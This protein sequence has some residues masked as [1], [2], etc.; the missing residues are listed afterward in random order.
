MGCTPSHSDIVNSVAKSGIQFF[1][2]PKA[3]LP[4]CQGASER[5]SIPFLVQNSTCYDSG[6]GSSQGQRPAEEQQ[7][8]RWIQSVAESLCQLTRDSTSGKRK[9]MEG[10][11]PETKTSP[12]QLNKS[13]SYVATDIPFKRQ[14]SHGS[15]GTA[16]SG[17]ESE[18]SNTQ[19]T[20][21]WEKRPKCHRSSKQGHYCQ[22]ILPAHESEDKVD[23]PEPLVKAHRRAYT[24]LHTCLSKYEAVLSITH[25]ATQ[26]Q[27]LLQP[28]VG[29]L[30]LCFDEVN[31]L[32]GEISKDGE[33]LLQEVKEDLAWPLKKREPQEQPD[34]LR[35]L[36]QYTVSKLQALSGTVASLSDSILEGSSCY[37][38]GAAGHLGN[39]LSKKRGVDERLLRVLGHLESLA[40]G[41]SD[42]EVQGLP[43]CSEDSGIGADSESV[44]LAD[45]MGK[46]ASWDF[47]LEPAEWRP[48]ISPTAESRLSG[49]TWQHSPFW[50]G[51]ARPQDCPL[52]RPLTAKV[53]PAVQGGPGSPWPS[54]TGPENTA[55]RPWGL[56]QRAPCDSPGIRISREAHFPKDSRLMDTPP[57]SEGKDSSPEEEEDK[58]SC[59]S[60][61]AWQ[62]HTSHARPR[63]SP[64][65]AE[66]PFQPHPRRL[67]SPQDQEMILKMKE[68]I[69]ERIKFVSVPSEHQEWTEE[70]ERTMVP[71]RPNTASD[72]R[73]APSRQRRSQSEGCLKSHVEDP[74]L[75]ELQRVQRD[76]SQRL[77]ALCTRGTQQQG[78]SQKQVLQPRATALRPDNCC[79]V[80]PSSTI[81]KL[82]AS[83]TKNFSILPS[84]STLQKCCP[85]PEGEQ[86]WQGKAEGLPNVIPSGERASEAPRAR[87][88]NIRSCPTRTSVKKLIETFSPNEGLRTLGDSK[89]SGP[90]PCPRKWGVP[91]MPPRFPI[92]RGLAPLY[93]KPRISPTAGGESLRMGPGWR[94][95]APT[96]LPLLTAEASKSEDLNCET[97]DNP[98][99]LPP[100]PLEILMDKSFTS[101]E[102]PENSN[103]AES[104]LEGTDVPGLGGAGPARRTWASPKL[105]AAM[106]PSDLLPSKSTATLARARSAEP[107]SSKRGCNPGKLALDLSHPPA[108]SGNPEVQGSRAQSQA[109]AD[110]ATG[111]SKHPRKVIH[112]HHSSHTSGQNRTLE[113]SLARPMR[114]PHS[115]EAPRQNQ[116]RSPALLRKASPTR[117][118]WTPRVGKRHSSL[119]STHR[120]A[121]PSVP[122][123]H[124]SP[125]PPLSP[126]VSPR[127]LSPPT[128]KKRASPPPQHK[129]S[130]PPSASPPAQHKVSGPPAQCTE[131]SSPASG[132]SPSPP[133][134][135]SQGPKETRDSEDS[136][137][138]TA[139]ASG[140]TCSIFCPATSSLF[141]AKS[142]FST[143]PQLTPPL[144]P[145]EAGG[146]CGTPTG[147]WRS[148]SGPRP[149][150]DSQ[151]GTALC[152]LNPQP[153]IRR[154]ASDCRPGIRLHLP[155]PGTTSD[156]CESQ[157]GQSSSSEEG[158]KDTE[159][160]NSPC[161][162]EPKGGSR[163]A[164]PPEL[165]VLGHGL[166]REA[167]ASHA[168]DKPQQKE[169]A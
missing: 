54:S 159:P 17:E 56:G 111:L 90:S 162:P 24:Y 53:Q 69:S 107:R 154:T 151:R 50:M 83:L 146:P 70:E 153:F 13:Q 102:P 66:S 89:D 60:P 86:P 108:A 1:K 78:Y 58:E 40:S 104:S 99:H 21:K 18:E 93:P 129:L 52:S 74:T 148:S 81:S 2:K 160:W 138:A 11:I 97:E 85:H 157:L 8:P 124:R 37:F 87:D 64:A 6:G 84:Q 67:R 72:S 110:R 75:Q 161:A 38:H 65:G 96:F 135:P 35:Q 49:H 169:V 147:C 156:A 101:L 95:F 29:F 130:T 109:R 131:A 143:V 31:Q 140:N 10:L 98:E 166:Q 149:R 152:A 136:R 168:Q 7:S 82:K 43:L 132:P 41:H 62:G 77:E 22:T 137:A 127:V 51:S 59:L 46:Q 116:D 28:M 150:A 76:L 79:K 119:P 57:L 23:F 5:C 47:V 141:E 103:L 144:L 25:C 42:P 117:A 44:Q 133:A 123:V 142:P 120:P 165:C 164:S 32:L 112:W 15:Q 55:A 163:G 71:P 92:Y 36:L 115:P 16:F 134:S 155:A 139:K 14:S 91:T 20:S 80:T 68:A 73:K 121:Q 39:K 167:S 122:C 30:L 48:A 106:S 26:T 88:W 158:P 128:V 125:S 27:E 9:D 19:E 145:P 105:R 118:H 33:E 45:K 61:R 3:I 63:S 34:L 94:P 126:P 113:P 114:G 100:P 4:G 12:S